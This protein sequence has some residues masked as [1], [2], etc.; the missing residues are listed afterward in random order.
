MPAE[1]FQNHTGLKVHIPDHE[2]LHCQNH[3]LSIQTQINTITKAQICKD[4]ML[5][6]NT[7]L[8]SINSTENTSMIYRKITLIALILVLSFIVFAQN[9]TSDEI[10]YA[11][12]PTNIRVGFQDSSIIITWQDSPDH[13]GSYNIYRSL[14]LPDI[15]NY[16]D[17]ELLG[18]VASGIQKFSYKATDNNLYYYF[19]LPVT[20]QK[21]VIEIFIPLQNYTL[22]P[23]KI[24]TV[25]QTSSVQTLTSSSNI[26]KNF[27][28]SKHEKTVT[29]QC[30]VSNYTGKV[31]LYRSQKPF[32]NS[33]SLL[34][35]VQ[36]KA[37]DINEP[38]SSYNLTIEDTPFPGIQYYWCIV[39]EFEISSKNI[40]FVDGKN[41]ATSATALPFSAQNNVALSAPRYAPLP[42][43]QSANI[44]LPSQKVE[45]FAFSETAQKNILFVYMNYM[46]ASG[47]K[48]PEIMY[49]HQK[50]SQDAYN[51]VIILSKIAETYFPS[52][53]Y[54][55]IVEE[56]TKFIAI[57]RPNI[58]KACALL[59]RA[60]AN[61]LSGRYQ[62]ALLDAVAA[63][64][65][66][67]QEADIW[68]SYLVRVLREQS[69]ATV[70]N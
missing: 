47:V 2:N 35:A 40:V 13:A 15:S 18:S 63:Y 27:S 30:T 29:I 36:I 68:I 14:K 69:S 23:V 11:P 31:Y 28:V 45:S 52:K 4:I 39:T 59:Y 20:A 44:F 21:Q 41:T 22:V 19:I 50:L 57:P 64:E 26:F 65:A 7:I 55:A 33:L 53:Q 12:Y 42:I 70:T 5:S 1:P 56:L 43:L 58:I 62:N 6:C 46:N 24:D 49:V 61:A 9:A 10:V 48:A 54:S 32:I 38:K 25:V 3:K 66:F 16:K 37:M 60:Q 51:E 67:P 8:F 34:E 17:A